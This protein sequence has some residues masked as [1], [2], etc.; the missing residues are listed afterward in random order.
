MPEKVFKLGTP[1]LAG[2]A[3]Q[4]DPGRISLRPV[5]SAT[6]FFGACVL[7]GAFIILEGLRDNPAAIA[8]AAGERLSITHFL[9]AAS[10]RTERRQ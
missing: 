10:G 9:Q 2:R 4:R 1:T 7:S 6:R 5:L 8:A 3:R